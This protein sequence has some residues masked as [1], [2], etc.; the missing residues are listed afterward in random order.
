MKMLKL[1]LI[2]GCLP[3]PNAKDVQRRSGLQDTPT[4]SDRH[5][6]YTQM[7]LTEFKVSK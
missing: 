3:L 6:K 5:T 7:P 2:S 4:S 1:K